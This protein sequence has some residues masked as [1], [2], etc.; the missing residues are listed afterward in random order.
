MPR[1]VSRAR[2]PGTPAVFALLVAATIAAFFVTTRLKRSTPVVKQLTFARYISPNGDGRHDFVDV[3]FQIKKPDE[4]TL[5]VESDDGDEIRVLA[6]DRKLGA[7]RHRLRWNGRT[8]AGTVAP[9]GVYRLKV[10]LRKQGRSVASRRKLFVDTTPPHPVVRY[11]TPNSISPD[12]AGT[13]NTA[14]LRFNGPTRNP[15]TLFVYRTDVKKPRLVARRTGKAASA[16]LSWDGLVGLHRSRRPAPTGNYALVAQVQDAAGNRNPSVLPAIRGLV[17]GHPGLVVRYLGALGPLGAARAGKPVAFKVQSD[18]R[19]Y[20]WLIRRLGSSHVIDRGSSAA[21]NLHVRAPRGKSGVFLLSLRS[22]H[23]RYQCPF[24]VQARKRGRVLVV[25]PSTTWQARNPPDANGDGFSDLLPDDRAVRIRRP[26]AGDGLPAGFTARE[27]PLLLFLDRARLRYD[28]TSDL[29]IERGF[30]SIANRYRGT[31]FAGSPRFFGSRTA[32]LVMSYV[33][34][35]GRVA[36]VG[37]GGFT[38]PID[39]N[40]EEVVLAA[41]AASDDRNVFGERLQAQ[42]AGQLA[43]LT[44]R[45][46]FFEGAGDVLGPFPRLEQ[47]TRL[48]A[49]AKMLA[50]AGSESNR[51]SVVV[52][53]RSRGIVARVGADGFGRAANSSAG[54]A[55]IMRRLWTL[56]SR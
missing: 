46:A 38:Q 43:V 49:G 3:G 45:I 55:R 5:T 27:A 14:R 23:H 39:A 15:P 54:A 21:Q 7:G 51:P 2:L 6:R 25:L 8:D 35:G 31:L 1:P 40:R 32:K 17:R 36:W 37:T 30:S 56:L 33:R 10:G 22:G 34:S 18:G 48:P 11:V 9:D 47:S 26:F 50:S 19:R 28:I 12:G 20:K 24:A 29:A 52:Y 44:D 13:N 41:G 53:R 4:I 42:P 16:E